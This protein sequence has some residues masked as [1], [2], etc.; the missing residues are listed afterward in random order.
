MAEPRA[1]I[2]ARITAEIV[3]AIERG[4]GEWRMPW[5]HD[6]SSLAQAAQRCVR[7]NQPAASTSWR[8]GQLRAAAA[9]GAA[10]GAPY[11]Q[12]SE[13]GC[14]VRK[15]ERATAIVFWKQTPRQ[16]GAEMERDG[17]DRPEGDGLERRP[18][19]LA[20][21]Y[22]VFDA[23]QVDGYVPDEIPS[24]PESERIAHAD[25]FFAALKIPIVTGA[26]DA[27]Y[28]PAIDTVFMPAATRS[29]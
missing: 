12:W 6:G 21:G 27:C 22:S 17:F 5:N 26:A 23:A 9:T 10:S 2:Y 14:Q 20:R 29:P 4:A 11:R 28:R 18:R 7:S 13:L 25:A 1:D 3:S 24:L 16:E 19:L 15:G 8:S